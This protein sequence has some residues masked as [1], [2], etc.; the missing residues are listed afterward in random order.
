MGSDFLL[1]GEAQH[2]EYLIEMGDK[3]SQDLNSGPLALIPC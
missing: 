1:I 3:W 2:V